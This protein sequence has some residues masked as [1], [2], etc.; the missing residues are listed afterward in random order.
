MSDL[1]CRGTYLR[2]RGWITPL[3]AAC[4]AAVASHAL[5]QDP[6]RLTLMVSGTAK[7]IYLPA[8]LAQRLGYFR[9]EG[10]EVE[11]LSQPA[12]VDAESELLTGFAQGVVGFYDHTLQAKGKEVR[13]IVVF[14]QVPGEAEVVST[15]L[16]ATVEAMRD[17]R[18]HKLGVTGLGSSTSFLT[19]YLMAQQGLSAGDYTMLPVGAE[20][21]FISALRNGRID[22]G[23]TTD[24]TV[25]RL[26]RNGEARVLLDLRTLEN[27]RAA[28]GGSYPAACLYLQ[29]EWLEAHPDI[30]AKLARAFVRTLRYMHARNAEDIAAR[31]PTEFHGE[32]PELYVKTLATALPTFSA[33]GRMPDDGPPTVLRVL[34]ASNANARGKHIDLSRTYTNKFVEQV[35]KR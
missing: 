30:A 22:A 24:P 19:R 6:T 9:D 17:L 34:A 4:M 27:T 7:M 5:A 13:A 2:L 23:M 3:L 35:R 28:L 33:D 32:H 31:M 8:T 14:S 18:G 20:R 29:T 25:S 11:L 12:G 26:V 16:P 15:R 1:T 10:L 21:S